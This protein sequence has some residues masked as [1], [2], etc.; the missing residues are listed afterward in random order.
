MDLCIFVNAV[1][2]SLKSYE[3]GLRDQFSI[4]EFKGSLHADYR[5]SNRRVKLRS[6]CLMGFQGIAGEAVLQGWQKT[7]RKTYVPSIECLTDGS[8]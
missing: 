5:H 1:I 8:A 7:E 6:I 3:Q 2:N 4:I